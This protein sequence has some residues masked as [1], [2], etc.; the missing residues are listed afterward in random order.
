MLA[1][2]ADELGRNLADLPF[3]LVYLLDDD[4][5]ARLGTCAGIAPGGAAAPDDDRRGRPRARLA[6]GPHPRR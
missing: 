3:S 1:A 5:T 6:A 4:G 2:V